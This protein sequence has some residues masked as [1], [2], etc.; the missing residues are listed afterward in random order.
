MKIL[1]SVCIFALCLF[2]MTDALMAQKKE[3]K[4]KGF[5]QE[6]SFDYGIPIDEFPT[7]PN[8]ETAT[9]VVNY[10]LD[11]M[12]LNAGK[13]FLHWDEAAKV[14]LYAYLNPHAE[15]Y[16]L[17]A[18]DDLSG[19]SIPVIIEIAEENP[20][21]IFAYVGPD[22]VNTICSEK[23]EFEPNIDKI[24]KLKKYKK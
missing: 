19:K 1:K 12:D 8:N 16:S 4:N 7:P 13:N 11:Y 23:F 9:A 10:K 21:C 5:Q 14:K 15:K 22:W 18:I 20:H 2:L 3:G 17:M 6:E 24:R